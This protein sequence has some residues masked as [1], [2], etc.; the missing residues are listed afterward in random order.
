MS[1]HKQQEHHVRPYKILAQSIGFLVCILLLLFVSGEGIPKVIHPSREAL[2]F[3]VTL[4][5]LC[6]FGFIL[7][8]FRERLGASVMAIGGIIVL[9]FFIYLGDLNMAAL[10]GIPFIITGVLFMIHNKKRNE[11]KSEKI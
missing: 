7:T 2:V 1:H 4:F 6:I 5:C 8:W 9:I 3:F 11:L 10:F